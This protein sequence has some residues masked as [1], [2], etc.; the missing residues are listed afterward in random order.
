MCFSVLPSARREGSHPNR[1]QQAQ[2]AEAGGGAGFGSGGFLGLNSWFTSCVAA[3]GRTAPATVG[4]RY[5]RIQLGPAGESERC[6]PPA[7]GVLDGGRARLLPSWPPKVCRA[8]L[9]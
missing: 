7:A 3:L 1:G 4:G 2:G 5:I 8:I 9:R 6:R